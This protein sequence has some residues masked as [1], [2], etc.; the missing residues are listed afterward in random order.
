MNHVDTKVE[1]KS[2]QMP[3]LV[4]SRIAGYFSPVYQGDK[5]FLW[6]KGKTSEYEERK[7]YLIPENLNG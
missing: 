5:A 7:E 6:N 2:I 1:N 4:F 3:A